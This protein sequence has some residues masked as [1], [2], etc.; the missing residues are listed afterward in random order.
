MSPQL[1]S[2]VSRVCV[3][4]RVWSCLCGAQ[5]GLYEEHWLSSLLYKRAE[6]MENRLWRAGW[7]FHDLHKHRNSTSF[8]LCFRR[9]W[10]GSSL[11]ERLFEQKRNGLCKCVFTFEQTAVRVGYPG[12]AEQRLSLFFLSSLFLQSLQLLQELELRARV[13][14]LTVSPITLN[15]EKTHSDSF[16]HSFTANHT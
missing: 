10:S 14:G 9:C 12:D 11:F 16:G 1:G 4:V 15:T 2:F 13:T 5:M 3:Y 7:F 6:G 8:A